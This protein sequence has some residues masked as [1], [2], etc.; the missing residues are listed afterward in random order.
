MKEASA[1]L[2]VE[3]EYAD[4]PRRVRDAIMFLLT[5][6]RASPRVSDTETETETETERAG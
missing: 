2:R 6:R 4:E 5:Y 1:P 3:V